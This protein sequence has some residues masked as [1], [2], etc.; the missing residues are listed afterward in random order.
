MND[1]KEIFQTPARS[2]KDKVV[3]DSPTTDESK[4]ALDAASEQHSYTKIVTFPDSLNQSK[5]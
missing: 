2:L 3:S 5:W 1:R 4:S